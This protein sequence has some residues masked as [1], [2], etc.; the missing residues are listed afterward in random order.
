[1]IQAVAG[2]LFDM[3]SGRGLFND[4]DEYF[5]STQVFACLFTCIFFIDFKMDNWKV[6][7][8]FVDTRAETDDKN[9]IEYK[10]LNWLDQLKNDK[11]YG[12]M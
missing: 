2:L 4:I 10:L 9:E 6:Q 1:M 11:H 7:K 5:A 12:A 8:R 3:F